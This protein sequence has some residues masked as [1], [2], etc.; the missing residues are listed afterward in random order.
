MKKKFLF[1]ILIVL[2]FGLITGC[3]SSQKTFEIKTEKISIYAGQKLDL[4]N[5]LEYSDNF[6]EN[7]KTKIISG[8]V[9]NTTSGTYKITI[10]ASANDRKTTS[11]E[12]IVEVKDFESEDELCDYAN[13]IIEDNKIDGIKCSLNTGNVLNIGDISFTKNVDDTTLSF[14]VKLKTGIAV[15]SYTS[16][17]NSL[18]ENN[19]FVLS[20][21]NYFVRIMV[22]VVKKNVNLDSNKYWYKAKNIAI[23]SD[24]G[25][26]EFADGDSFVNPDWDRSS[27]RGTIYEPKY[28]MTSKLGYNI[29]N[30]EKFNNV[31]S[32]D[33]IMLKIVLFNGLN[34]DNGETTL[35]VKLSNDD[36]LK[37]SKI[38]DFEN[39]FIYEFNK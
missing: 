16:V 38:V 19:K 34:G 30:L 29:N 21:D 10:E 8:D 6:L 1:G 39:L 31:I 27:N 24:N 17:Q 35:E 18:S 4:Q 23:V 11:K 5:Y 22:D 20:K 2:A 15:T 7:L 3:G 33:N 26:Y 25:T 12:I 32:G 14:N 37:L 36:K 9:D 13:K 28:D